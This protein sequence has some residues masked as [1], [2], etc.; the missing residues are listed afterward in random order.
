MATLAP[1]TPIAGAAAL[2]TG[3]NRGF[4]LA[5]VNELLSR[6][7]ARVYA[8]SRLAQSSADPRVV[9]LV[10][11][12][13]DEASIQAAAQAAPDISILVNNAGVLLRSKVLTSPLDD[14][15]AEL[16]T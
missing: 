4:G 5:L 8:T 7:A 11:D 14:I 1:G 12:V 9:P 15:R 16:D 13:T 2:V 3:G 6:G 10:L